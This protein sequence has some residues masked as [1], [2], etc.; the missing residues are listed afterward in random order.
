[1]EDASNVLLDLGKLLRQFLEANI[2]LD[3]N[4]LRS[5][6]IS[7]KDEIDLITAYVRFEQLQLPFKFNYSID[8]D[9]SIDIENV[10]IPPMLIQPFVENAIKHGIK[11][12]QDDL[13]ELK[14]NF[15]LANHQ[16]LICT[17]MDNGVGRAKTQEVYKNEVKSHK[18]RGTYL[19]EKRIELMKE[20]NF[21]IELSITDVKSGGTMVTI[22]FEL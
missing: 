22:E 11:H 17:I 9:K 6:E 12:R 16:K 7:I 2:N 1:M 18:S 8:Y 3:I 5:S 15:N 13:G 21:G 14:V 20:M 10:C 4:K 19:V